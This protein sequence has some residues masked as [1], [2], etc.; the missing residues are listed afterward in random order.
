M[1]VPRGSMSASHRLQE[2]LL[3]NE[4]GSIVHYFLRVWNTLEMN[5]AH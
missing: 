5:Q 2:S 3:F 1:G 4:E